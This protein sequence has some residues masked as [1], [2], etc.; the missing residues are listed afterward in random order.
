MSA[1]TVFVAR[2]AG[3]GVF[4]PA[5]ERIGKVRDVVA[6]PR[7]DASPRVVGLVVESRASGRVFLSI[8]RV[9]SIGGGQLIASAVS[10]RRFRQR[11]GERLLLAEVLGRGVTLRDGTA[12]T[13]E[14]LSISERGPG[15]WE[16]D[17]LFLRKPKTG[18]FGKGPTTLA[19]WGDVQH[20]PGA[21]Q[22]TEHL[23]AS[24]D[25]LAAA[26]AAS[27]LLDL[28]QQRMMEVAED[29]PDERLAD[30]LE[31]MSED[32]QIEILDSLEDDRA[33]DVLDQMEPDDAADLIAQLPA[34]RGET[35]LALMDPEE[36]EDV[37]MLLAFGAD[38]AGGLMTTEPIIL[39]SDATVAEALA[40]VRRH[41]FAP[42]LAAAVCVTLPPYEAPTGRFL[43]MVHFQRLLRYPPNER[44]G[45]L[46]DEQ[47]E[48]VLVSDTAAEVTRRMAS[49]NLVSV[50]VVD[51]ARRLVGIVT[52]D[53]VLDHVLPADWRAQEEAK[54]G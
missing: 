29:L 14:D 12:A 11:G 51:P 4:D 36:A 34:E 35:L 1:A 20:E 22:G 26:D 38:T 28:P 10:D 18:P 50:P 54:R 19:H 23:L 9:T 5:G 32:R 44:L 24:L 48:P 13:L 3:A 2:L 31:E 33:A 27:A 43:G 40:M 25:D 30:I 53:D 17:E 41:E 46:L 8:G 37:R 42:A 39:A 15:E 7:A 21:E 52:I 49:Y 6:V 47:I 16:V 45:T